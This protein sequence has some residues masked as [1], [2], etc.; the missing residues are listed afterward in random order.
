MRVRAARREL[1][2]IKL[3]L[4]KALRAGRMEEA[5]RLAELHKKIY[6]GAATAARLAQR[7]RRPLDAEPVRNRDV[8]RSESFTRG[9]KLGAERLAILGLL[10]PVVGLAGTVFGVLSLFR[11]TSSE[12]TLNLL[13]LAEGF[14]KA[15]TTTALSLLVAIPALSMFKA[16]V[17]KT[18]ELQ[19]EERSSTKEIASLVE[20]Q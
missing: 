5:L 6:I 19:D 16:L 2:I 9:L 12:G 14:E 18:R 20:K 8:E 10:A 1:R 3:A 7:R 17:Q 11:S 15:L 13:F 4:D